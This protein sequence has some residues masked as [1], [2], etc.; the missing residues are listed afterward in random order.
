VSEPGEDLNSQLI[1]LR[2]AQ[3]WL[4]LAE[5]N[6]S[7][8]VDLHHNSGWPAS[9]KVAEHDHLRE[10]LYTAARLAELNMGMATASGN[11]DALTL[12]RKLNDLGENVEREVKAE[13]SP[14]EV[15]AK[16][17]EQVKADEAAHQAATLLPGVD[18]EPPEEGAL[19]TDDGRRFAYAVFPLG[20]EDSDVYHPF[21][22]LIVK[23][24]A[25]VLRWQSGNVRHPTPATW[26]GLDGKIGWAD[27]M[28]LR[29][30][31]AEE[32]AAFY[33]PEPD[34]QPAIEET[35]ERTTTIPLTKEC[36]HRGM[37]D[38]PDPAPTPPEHACHDFVD[39]P[40]TLTTTPG[41]TCARCGA[42][43]T[44]HG[45]LAVDAEGPIRFDAT[46]A[47]FSDDAVEEMYQTV[48]RE[49]IRRAYTAPEDRPRG[50]AAQWR[51]G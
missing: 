7:E 47:A 9:D 27:D 43:N 34:P 20:A 16:I 42:S 40:G 8:L 24:Y 14:D 23:S 22:W 4:E 36:G 38:C 15:A 39:T 1:Y 13:P 32:R 33:G 26:E 31:T 17:R 6:R 30:P 2:Q 49:R 21:R 11:F 50:G 44:A 3:H 51:E 41:A 28:P 45:I 25:E 35:H 19:W 48:K 12:L 29:R 46:V 37:C 10:M 18:P 5:G